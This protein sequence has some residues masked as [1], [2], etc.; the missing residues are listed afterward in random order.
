MRSYDA[1]NTGSNPDAEAITEEVEEEW[2]VTFDGDDPA[3][4]WNA[5][6]VGDGRVYV[7]VAEAETLYAFDAADGEEVWSGTVET[8][9]EYTT[10]AVVDGTVFGG[11]RAP[12]L[13]A[14]D[15]ET[16][17]R[18]WTAD[19]DE[20]EGSSLRLADAIT[21]HDDLLFVCTENPPVVFAIE[22][23]SGEVRWREEVADY[24]VG[25]K[26]AATDDTAYVATEG[27]A[28]ALDVDDGTEEWRFERDGTAT[29]ST[30]AVVAEE[31]VSFASLGAGVIALDAADGDEVWRTEF[32]GVHETPLA[33]ADGKI[34][35]AAVI[36]EDRGEPY[37]EGDTELVAIADGEEEWQKRIE[38]AVRGGISA[39]G[40]TAYVA[41]EDTV[42]GVALEDGEQRWRYDLG[43]DDRAA[44]APAV[45]DGTL[46][47]VRGDTLFALGG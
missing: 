17:E 14:F 37:G 16:G 12:E 44:P 10:A 41:T 9:L 21:V 45:V 1:A 24:G 18:R 26:P 22:I 15:G 5:P 25:Y 4:W 8:G 23:E 43:D 31:T 3:T 19:V 35:A 30:P 32:D 29:A 28:V 36:S 11:G 38:G 46:F 7:P 13:S 6:V 20:S 39:T 34:L 40:D 2:S 27:G 47:V 33:A 42:L